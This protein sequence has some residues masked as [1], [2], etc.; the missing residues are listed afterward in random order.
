MLGS[1]GVRAQ[2]CPAHRRRAA[3]SWSPPDA[4]RPEVVADEPQAALRDVPRQHRVGHEV[5]R[6]LA[7]QEQ[8]VRL[9]C[10]RRKSEHRTE[11]NGCP[12]QGVVSHNGPE[13]SIADE[14]NMAIAVQHCA[15]D[16]V[17]R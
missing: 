17:C 1:K 12:H 6:V 5:L 7:R 8:R 10:C 14:A 16:T 2:A 3:H 15:N 11:C 9:E 13:Q 4:R